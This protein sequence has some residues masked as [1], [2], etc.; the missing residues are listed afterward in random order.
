MSKRTSNAERFA[1]LVAHPYCMPIVFY[2]A[3]RHDALLGTKYGKELLKIA[4]QL[5]SARGR[6]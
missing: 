3:G 2:L 4:S 5:V 6:A 1:A